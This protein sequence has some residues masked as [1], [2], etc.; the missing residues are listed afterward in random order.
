M[1]KYIGQIEKYPTGV[2]INYSQ[3][4]LF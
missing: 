3:E 2:V 4:L 1:F